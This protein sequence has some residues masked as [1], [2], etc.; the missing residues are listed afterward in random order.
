MRAELIAADVAGSEGALPLAA[1]V[2]VFAADS[3]REVI[4]AELSEPPRP[5]RATLLATPAARGLERELSARGLVAAARGHICHLALAAEPDSLEALAS[6]DSRAGL[7]L[8]HMPPLL[9]RESLEHPGLRPR[10]ALLG[11]T[12]PTDRPL[13]ALVAA[14]MR[15]EGVRVKLATKPLPLLAARRAT[16]GVAPGG[17]AGTRVARLA[18]ALL[19]GHEKRFSRGGGRLHP[20]SGRAVRRFPWRWARAP[21][22]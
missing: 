2:G 22:C 12:L 7:I 3:G 1:A 14:E 13:A 9:W 8:A 17:S 20:R 11:V 16:A 6:L 21:L 4:L 15:G 5:R 10:A 18:R 19:G